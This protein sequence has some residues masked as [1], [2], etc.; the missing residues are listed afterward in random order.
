MGFMLMGVLS[1]VSVD[2]PPPDLATT[3]VLRSQAWRKWG[4]VEGRLVRIHCPQV[5]LIPG[6]PKRTLHKFNAW[7]IDVERKDHTIVTVFCSSL[8]YK[9]QYLIKR[10]AIKQG[11]LPW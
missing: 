9:D 1:M 2:L 7:T 4:Q 6:P 11:A 8:L 3:L 10:L 5:L